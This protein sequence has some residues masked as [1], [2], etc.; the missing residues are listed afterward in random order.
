MP[1]Y[2]PN[3]G[4]TSDC[5]RDGRAGWGEILTIVQLV[6]RICADFHQNCSFSVTSTVLSGYV[7][8]NM[9]RSIRYG[10]KSKINANGQS[11][12]FPA[13]TYTIVLLLKTVKY[14]SC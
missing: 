7:D 14:L 8:F 13:C 11:F 3:L 10:A 4:T 2:D 1:L 5:R 12:A 9:V 6:V